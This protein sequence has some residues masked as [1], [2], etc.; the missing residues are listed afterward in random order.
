MVKSGDFLHYK[1]VISK[2]Y[3][4]PGDKLPDVM[5]KF[6][7]EVTGSEI[8]LHRPPFFSIQ[9]VDVDN[10]LVQCYVSISEDNPNLLEGLHFAS[11][12]AIDDMISSMLF[13]DFESKYISTVEEMCLY[14]DKNDLVPCT[15][16][17][18]VTGEDSTMRYLTLK[19][20]YTVKGISEEIQNEN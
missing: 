19:L 3:F 17:F 4:I 8:T 16:I 14:L 13:G 5:E 7:D 1:N 9:N 20:G 11:Y 15:P 10:I 6:F 2:S 12:F 18:I